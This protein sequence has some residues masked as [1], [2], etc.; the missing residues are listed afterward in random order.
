METR[1]SFLRK[2]SLAAASLA[3]LPSCVNIST[4]K[5]KVPMRSGKIKKAAVLW[6]SQTENTRK[7]GQVLA[8]TLE[9][10]GITVISGDIRDM[11]TLNTKD[12]DLLVIGSPVFYYDTS[13]FVKDYITGM[14]DLD[15]MPVAAF[16]TFGGPEGNQHNAGCSILDGL[17]QKNGVP[18]GLDAFVSI[19]SYSLTYSPD[20]KDLMTDNNTILPDASTY[21]RVRDYARRIQS[22]AEKGQSAV[23][24]KSLTARESLT[25]FDLEYWVKT[26][27]DNHQIIEKNCVKCGTCTDLCPT[28]SIDLDTY[29]VDTKKCVL[30]LGC[31]NNCEY[32]AMNME[33]SG[34]K[35]TGFKEY[36]ANNN[37]QFDLPPELI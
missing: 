17:V 2:G 26:S 27:V 35:V 32:Q 30:C 13:G 25:F 18:V 29:L 12:I 11:G 23:F 8:R 14:P 6:Y 4:I 34:K 37:L 28:G 31:V 21:K 3:L 22:V 36:L 9:K 33:Y 20:G 19:S 10:S 15:G 7:C 5:A 16:V 1:R 24:K